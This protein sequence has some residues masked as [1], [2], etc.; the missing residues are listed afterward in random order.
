MAFVN[1]IH[2]PAK[3][4]TQREQKA[5]LRV[6]GEHRA[7][8]RDHVIY[9]LALGTGLRA[10]ELLALNVGDVF[11]VEGRARR[12]IQLRVFKR[13]NPD[14]AAQ[15]VVHGSG[16]RAKLE[17]LRRWKQREGQV[18]APDAPIFVS[19][20][21]NRLSARQLGQGF[22]RWQEQAGF[23]RR[24]GFHAL[25]HTACTNLYRATRD[26]RLTQRFARHASVTTTMRYA[27]P[28][29]EDLVRAVDGLLDR[30][31]ALADGK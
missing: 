12:R 23:E 9:A 16:L 17:R 7:G 8:F 18:L 4:L 11:D 15:E 28:S 25:R 30:A 20:N 3:T 2:R 27:H 14:E 10:H 24:L 31:N 5:L 21:S 29:D 1:S 19:R 13:S 22:H 26:I 6:T